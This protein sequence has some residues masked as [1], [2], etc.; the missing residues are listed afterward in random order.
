MIFFESESMKHL[1]RSPH[2]AALCCALSFNALADSPLELPQMR[3]ST[4]EERKIGLQLDTQGSTGSRLGLTPRETPASVSVVNRQQI[5]QRGAANT[6]D[7]LASVP[8]MN[9]ASSP[10]VPGFVSYR[11]F[12]GAVSYT[13]LTLPTIYSV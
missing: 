3:I 6:Q 8:G 7:I 5:E 10:G 13:H 1:N 11:G 12:S 9:A 4:D 2:C